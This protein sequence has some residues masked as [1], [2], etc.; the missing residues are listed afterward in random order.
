MTAD[1]AEARDRPGNLVDAASAYEAALE[2]GRR[3]IEILVNLTVLYWQAT[4]FGVASSEKIS[5]EFQSRAEKR[6]V[7]LIEEI[8]RSHPSAP[9]AHFW[10]KYIPWAE[11]GSDFTPEQCREIIRLRPEYLDPWMFIFVVSNGNEGV[12]E[13]R[14]LRETCATNS[15]MRCRYITSMLNGT[16]TRVSRE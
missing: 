11:N 3:N 7:E 2:L 13:A 12:A 9:E 8:Q 14:R 4:D 5:I 1:E 16:F 6:Y 15:T 10:S